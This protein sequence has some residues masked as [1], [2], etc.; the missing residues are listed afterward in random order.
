MKGHYV[1]SPRE[2]TDLDEIWD[3]S[4]DTWGID[5]ADSYTRD[6]RRRC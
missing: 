1:L 6:Q 2:Q 3:Y 5:Q 4:A